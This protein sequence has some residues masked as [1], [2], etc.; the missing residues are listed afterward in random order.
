MQYK[1]QITIL[2]GNHESRQISQVYRFYDEC[3]IFCLHGGLSNSIDILDHIQALDHLQEV[4]LIF[5]TFK[6][7][8][9]LRKVDLKR[10][11]SHFLKVT[12]QL[13]NKFS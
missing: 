13:G 12:V 10:E 11:E 9:E 1:E 8:N 6:K 3:Q 2:R 7:V 4:S 5:I